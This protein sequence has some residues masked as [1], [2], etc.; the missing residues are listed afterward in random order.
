MKWVVQ[1]DDP[2]RVPELISRAFHVATS[3]RP[4]P[5]VVALPEDMLT[6]AATV[7]DALPYQVTRNAPRRRADGR[8]GAAPAS[9]TTARGHP[10]RQPL[11]RAGGARVHG[12]CRSVV[13][14][15]CTARF[16]RQMLFPAT[17]ACYGG[18]LG[19]GVNPSCWRASRRP[20]W[21]WWWAG[22]CPK[23]RRRATSCSTSPRPRS[24]GACACRCRRAGQALPPHTGHSRHAAGLCCGAQCGAP[25][26]ARAVERPTP[27]PPMPNTWPGR[28]GTHPH[29]RQ[30]AN[31][32]GDAAPQRSA[33]RRHHLS[34]TA[35]GNFATWIHRFWPFTHYASQLAPTSRVD[36]LRPACRRG[37]QAPVAAARSGGLCGRRRLSDA[38]PGNLRPP[39]ST[40]CPSSWCCWT[41]PCTAPSACTRSA[42]TPAA[43]APRSSRTPDFKAYAQ[44][45]GG[46]GER[47]ERT[48]DF[49]PALARA[50]ASGLPSVLHCLIDPEAITPTGT[51]QGILQRSVS[52]RSKFI[53]R[54]MKSDVS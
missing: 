32:P 7:A 10:G 5:V 14:S 50:R 25:T 15:R 54:R 35:L 27:K 19:L 17:H 36:G 1:I 39:C 29:P 18:D 46:H 52:P 41:T 28:P 8:A 20:T 4:G 37:R 26:A 53:H 47:V 9:R 31:G 51:L 45:F 30:P 21:C 16:R 33:A 12:V 6:E 44:A 40:A 48:E 3:G 2:A 22:A 43:S 11:V 13:H 42:S 34:A 49:A 23:C 24:P 38:R